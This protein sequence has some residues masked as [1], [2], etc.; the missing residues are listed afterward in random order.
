[1]FKK[2]T[3][4]HYSWKDRET[5]LND[6]D[7][8]IIGYQASLDDVQSGLYLFN[9][10]CKTTLALEVMK[11]DDLYDGPRFDKD[12]AETDECSGFCLHINELT[13]CG[14]QCKYAYIREIIQIIRNWP[15]D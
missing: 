1:M 13:V 10:Q 15:K 5:F 3:V 11:F 9:H 4:C 14:A 12:L 6:P 7:L 8:E 2:C